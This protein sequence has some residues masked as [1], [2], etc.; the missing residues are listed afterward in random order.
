MELFFKMPSKKARKVMCDASLELGNRP[1]GNEYKINAENSIKEVT[2]HKYARV[3]CSGNAAIM[4]VMSNLKGPI[5]VPDQGGW[6]G[7]MKIAKLFGLEIISVPT[8]MGIIHPET[9]DEHFKQIKPQ[10]L[11]ITSFAGYMAEQPVKEIYECCEDNGVILVE[12]A[13]GSVGDPRGKLA[14]GDTAHIILASTGSPKMVNLANGG[15]ISTNNPKIFEDTH[16]ILK[17]LQG[18]PVT[19]AGL[20]EEIKNAPENL[21]KTIKAC[22]FLKKEIKTVLH[23]DKSGINVAVPVNEPKPVAKTLRKEIKVNGGGMITVCPLYD[24][25]NK[26]AVC[27]E[28]KNLDI[29]CLEKNNLSEIA[30]TVNNTI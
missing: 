3:V 5:M 20:T 15:F 25:I 7:F 14:C 12:D 13:S 26:P 27:L 29:R 23:P 18:S 9:L 16:Y 10:S 28:I 8:K 11:F 19:C 30:E 2:G 6:S 1:R 17:T 24:R 21:L 4:A 22:E